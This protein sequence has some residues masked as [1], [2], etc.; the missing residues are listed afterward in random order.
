MNQNCIGTKR[1]IAFKQLMND[2]LMLHNSRYGGAAVESQNSNQIL[3]ITPKKFASWIVNEEFYDCDKILG[4]IR[5]GSAASNGIRLKFHEYSILLRPGD[6]WLR[7]KCDT[8][9]QHFEFMTYIFF[10]LPLFSHQRGAKKYKISISQNQLS[11]RAATTAQ[12]FFYHFWMWA[13][14]FVIEINWYLVWW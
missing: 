10:R 6:S 3:N 8:E 2:A 1:N 11:V 5:N 9:A 13:L 12:T 7:L 14:K 4:R